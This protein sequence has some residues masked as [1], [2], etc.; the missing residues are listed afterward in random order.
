MSILIHSKNFA[1]FGLQSGMK[2][3]V[4]NFIEFLLNIR[5]A[6]HKRYDS[7][8]KRDKRLF[9]TMG[10]YLTFFERIIFLI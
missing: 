6:L 8:K 7:S 1:H 9:N 2:T 4:A 10:K 3:L 5:D